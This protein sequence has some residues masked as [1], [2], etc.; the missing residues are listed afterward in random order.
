M[1]VFVIARRAHKFPE[2]FTPRNVAH[3]ML[4]F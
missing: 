4:E 1:A 3:L 2:E